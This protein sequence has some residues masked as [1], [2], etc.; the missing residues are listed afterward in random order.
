MFYIDPMY[1]LIVGTP[2]PLS[3]WAAFK[4]SLVGDA[5]FEPATSTV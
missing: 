1:F 5:G 2:M 4:V 3:M